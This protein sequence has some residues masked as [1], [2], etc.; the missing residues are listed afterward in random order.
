MTAEVL[1]GTMEKFS[2]PDEGAPPEAKIAK[3]LAKEFIYRKVGR[4]LKNPVRKECEVL[5]GLSSEIEQKHDML[6]KNMCNRLN[7][8]SDNAY[9]TFC[10]VADEV[11]KDDCNWGRIVVLYA[12]GGKLAEYCKNNNMEHMIDKVVSWVGNFISRKAQW[13]KDKGHGWVS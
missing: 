8:N 2:S 12:F 9:K 11:F 6:L 1:S 5:L 4:S 10:E 3:D 13:I 7:V